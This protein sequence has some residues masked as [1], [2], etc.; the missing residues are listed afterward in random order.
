VRELVVIDSARVVDPSI[1]VH[2]R[3]RSEPAAACAAVASGIS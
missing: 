3:Q 1:G 2:G